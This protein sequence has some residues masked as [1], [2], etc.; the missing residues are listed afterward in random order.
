LP[1]IIFSGPDGAGKSTQVKLLVQYLKEKNIKVRTSW[2]RA[3]HSIALPISRLLIRMGFC[4]IVSNPYGSSYRVIDLKK[5]PILRKLWPYLEIFSM[6]PLVLLRVVIPSSL[7]YVVV[8]ERFS[9]DSIASIAWLTED[10]AFV[11]SRT[12]RFLL[13]LIKPKYCLINLDC[14]YSTLCQRRGIYTEPQKFI[15]IQKQVYSEL[16]PRL[17]Y[18]ELNTA[19]NSLQDTQRLIRAHVLNHLE[20]SGIR[21]KE[22]L[23]EQDRKHVQTTA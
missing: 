4:R 6:L 16:A 11:N 5:V 21:L 2:I 7:G 14:D 8:S 13:G 17:Q 18:W 20:Q 9:L 10:Q 23:G 19:R 22:V 15:E 1:V 3:L 12:A